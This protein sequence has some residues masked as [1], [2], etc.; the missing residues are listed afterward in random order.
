M[1]AAIHYLS[2][3]NHAADSP[4]V[5]L[6]DRATSAYFRLIFEGRFR[7]LWPSTGTWF[8]LLQIELEEI[9]LP[10]VFTYTLPVLSQ[11]TL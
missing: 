11:S 9:F 5:R 4:P 6:V 3:D 8:Q 10:C 1:A 7:F 2:A